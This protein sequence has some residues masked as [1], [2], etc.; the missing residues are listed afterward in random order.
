[1][2]LQL[3]AS[4]EAR[5]SIHQ[6]IRDGRDH[7]DPLADLLFGA[8]V[9]NLDGWEDFDDALVGILD[10]AD[11]GPGFLGELVR[12]LAGTPGGFRQHFTFEVGNFGENEGRPRVVG[13]RRKDDS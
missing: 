12:R 9:G 1:M 11:F 10:I 7:A 3:Q 5:A 2:T 4:Q 6:E 13:I 8:V